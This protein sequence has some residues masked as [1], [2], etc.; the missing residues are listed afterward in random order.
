MREKYTPPQTNESEKVHTASFG[1]TTYNVDRLIELSEKLPTTNFDISDESRLEDMLYSKYW[2]ISDG[3][4]IGPSDLL[5]AYTA[6]GN[7]WNA[8]AEAHPEWKTHIEKVQRADYSYP[9]LVYQDQI[10]DGIHRLVKALSEK[11]AHLPAK[12]IEELPDSAEHTTT[13]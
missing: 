11:A 13:Q 5:D 12:I 4:D 2:H 1:D 3:S 6:A 10:I 7:D 9:M 8:A